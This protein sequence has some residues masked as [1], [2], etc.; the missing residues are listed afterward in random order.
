MDAHARL[1]ARVSAEQ[2]DILGNLQLADG[3]SDLSDRMFDQLVDLL[4]ES[5]FLD[6]REGYLCG[7]VRR[8]EYVE[9]LAETADRCRRVGLLPL[10]SRHF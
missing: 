5:L 1:V 6:L 3:D 4:V 10:P 7:A 2:D 8:E 9:S